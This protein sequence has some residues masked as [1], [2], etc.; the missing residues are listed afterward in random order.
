VDITSKPYQGGAG[1]EKK[2][3]EGEK[4]S[5]H[6]S[7]AISLEK[8]SQS[9][10][11]YHQTLAGA[12]QAAAALREEGRTRGS[13]RVPPPRHLFTRLAKN[14]HA[15]GMARV[16][17]GNFEPAAGVVDAGTLYA[18]GRAFSGH[19]GHRQHLFAGSKLATWDG[20]QSHA[21]SRLSMLITAHAAMPNA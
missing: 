10:A 11:F 8:A 20:A 9:C 14:L 12:G 2:G 13:W 7:Y 4:G 17:E 5:R 21:P 6:S 15:R 16:A 18:T 1:R 3:K 19:A